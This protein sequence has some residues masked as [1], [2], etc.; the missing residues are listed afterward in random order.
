MT[1]IGVLISVMVLLIGVIY[2]KRVE[3]RVTEII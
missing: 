3:D 2:F 1:L